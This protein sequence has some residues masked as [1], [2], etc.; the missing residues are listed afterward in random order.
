MGSFLGGSAPS[1][2]SVFQPS[3]TAAFD[4]WY[5]NLT[6]DSLNSNPYNTYAP[7][8]TATYNTAA[9]NPFAP[10]LLSASQNAGT[11]LNTTGNQANTAAPQIN[12]AASSLLPATGQIL[13]TAFDPQQALYQKT[14]Q[15]TTDAANVNNAQSGTT[16]SPYGASVANNANQNFNID[17]QA[18]QLANQ[19]AGLGAAGAGVTNAANGATSAA[20]LGATGAQDIA[21]AGAIPYNAQQTITG[22]QSAALQTLLQVL[23]NSGAGA[24]NTADLNAMMSYLGLGASQS[25]IQAQI[26]QQAQQNAQSGIGSLLGSV[27]GA[28]TSLI[29]GPSAFLNL[30]G[31][32]G[33]SVAGSNLG[34]IGTAVGTD[35]LAA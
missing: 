26:N 35:I 5:Q 13:N 16:G 2:Q 33:S 11:A 15:Q 4:Q 24:W 18:Q 32:V 6:S 12:A 23:G 25:D 30:G 17:W 28:G 14:V 34:N 3:G 8:A 10:G 20:N 7:A 27:L 21:N 19:I 22:D 29:N 1:S 31:S 9:N